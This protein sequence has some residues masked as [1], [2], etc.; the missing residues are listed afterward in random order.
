MLCHVVT[1]RATSDLL[2]VQLLGMGAR[3]W[4][5]VT[6]SHRF[7]KSAG[8]TWR[9][10]RTA[11]GVAGGPG[12]VLTW[13]FVFDGLWSAVVGVMTETVRGFVQSVGL[14]ERG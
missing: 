12:A 9:R 3:K 7:F 5:R 10:R 8:L 6:D 14:V 2:C 13:A 11:T 4:D 1:L